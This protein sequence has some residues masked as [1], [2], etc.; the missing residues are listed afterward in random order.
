MDNL[1]IDRLDERIL[2]VLQESGRISFVELAAEVGLSKTPCITR[3]RRLEDAG[4]IQDYAANLNPRMLDCGYVV[5]VEVKLAKTTQDV[6]NAFNAAVRQI[7][8]I[9]SCHMVSGG[10]DYLLKIRTKDMESYTALMIETLSTL[11]SVVS[12]STYP[13]M[14]EVKDSAKLPIKRTT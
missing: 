3:V 2:Q 7:E 12:T 13:A 14:Q 9:Q 8:E 4:Y 5:F 10:F 11:P 6:L 1:Q